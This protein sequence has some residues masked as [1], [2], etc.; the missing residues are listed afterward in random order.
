M[1]KTKR[2]L[3][4]HPRNNLHPLSG[5]EL[6][7]LKKSIARI[8][9]QDE[10][11]MFE[12]KILD[13]WHRYLC[14]RELGRA[15]EYD[16]FD[17]LIK[18]ATHYMVAFNFARRSSSKGQKAWYAANILIPMHH[19]ENEPFRLP[20][21]GRLTAR[22][23]AMVGVSHDYVRRAVKLE[24]ENP[25]LSRLVWE[26]GISLN[27]AVQDAGL[28]EDSSI[29]E[30]PKTPTVSKASQKGDLSKMIPTVDSVRAEPEDDTDLGEMAFEWSGPVV[31]QIGMAIV[32]RLH[33]QEGLQQLTETGRQSP[34]F[35]KAFAES[36]REMAE[37]MSAQLRDWADWL[38]GKLTD[39]EIDDRYVIE[40]D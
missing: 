36:L 24:D 4:R 22:A 16:E 12:G 40:T 2:K 26:R 35:K 37:D 15:W 27:A 10:G 6:D 29:G 5:A 13:G 32:Q 23:G 38:E 1:P 28:S 19:D 33:T 30:I 25:T 18:A 34:K 17:G 21:R 11:L 39:E 20:G 14:C 3:E 31:Q 8:G 7:S 9:Q